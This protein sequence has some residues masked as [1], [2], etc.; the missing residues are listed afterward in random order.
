MPWLRC[1][2]AN[3]H[4]FLWLLLENDCCV[5]IITVCCTWNSDTFLFKRVVNDLHFKVNIQRWSIGKSKLI[6]LESTSQQLDTCMAMK[7]ARDRE[8]TKISPTPTPL[9]NVQHYQGVHS[10][11]AQV[12]KPNISLCALLSPLFLSVVTL[13][14][15][16]HLGWIFHKD[17]HLEFSGSLAFESI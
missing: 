11:S 15:G 17:G 10:V 6:K 5:F 7:M 4:H 2:R 1:L 8:R 14:Q 3:V 9:H 16:C 13:S 12:A